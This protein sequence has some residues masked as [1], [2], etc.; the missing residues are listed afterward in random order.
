MEILKKGELPQEKQA[1]FNCNNC[2]S[3]LRAKI[4]EGKITYD[5]R[6]GDYVTFVCP[7]CGQNIYVDEKKFS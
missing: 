2:G 4:S 5:Q 6:D 7:V 1:D 3:E